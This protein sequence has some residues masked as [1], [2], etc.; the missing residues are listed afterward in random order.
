[1]RLN[2]AKRMSTAAV[3]ITVLAVICLPTTVVYAGPLDARMGACVLNQGGATNNGNTYMAYRASGYIVRVSANTTSRPLPF[4]AQRGDILFST[5]AVG[6]PSLSGS[7]RGQAA[8]LYLCPPGTTEKF[9]GNGPL[10]D[11][12][13]NLYATGVPGIG[14][15][16]F[17]YIEDGKE[18]AAPYVANNPY[19][20]G[21]LVFPLNGSG[22]S[23]YLTTRIDFVATGEPIQPGTIQASRIFGQVTVPNAG[24]SIPWQL[25][26]VFLNQD[27]IITVPTCNVINTAALNMTLP[28][29][30]ASQ[31]VVGKGGDVIETNLQVNCST[32][33]MAAP[34]LKITANNLV[35]GQTATLRNQ[36]TGTTGAKGVGVQLSVWD[37]A[38]GSFRAPAIGSE[39]KNVGTAIGGLPTKQW[40][41]RLGANYKQVDPTVRAGDVRA[42]ATLTFTYM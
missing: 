26:K 33:S 20:T 5:P 14:Y 28:D 3:T 24:T 21:A 8:P 27:I 6:L 10:I 2:R 36:D 38:S 35:S 17:Y 32:A 40:S 22:Y 30:S 42:S 1:M 37:P 41:Y 34:S 16:V 13:Y 12:T 7:A 9:D 39:E 25:Y 19:K 18:I 23:G 29:V 15:R 4:S 11:S 31:L